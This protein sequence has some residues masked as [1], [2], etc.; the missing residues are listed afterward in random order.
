M[1]TQPAA[2]TS[3]GFTTIVPGFTIRLGVNHLSSR[4]KAELFRFLLDDLGITAKLTAEPEA[5]ARA[6]EI[7][8]EQW[9]A[10][11]YAK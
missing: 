2:A 6:Q 4:D 10:H 11:W 9:D 7:I 5:T 8:T 1:L 3:F